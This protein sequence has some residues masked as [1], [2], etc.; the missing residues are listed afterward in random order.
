MIWNSLFKIIQ[1]CQ[2]TF[3]GKTISIPKMRRYEMLQNIYT[4]CFNCGNISIVNVK[5]DNDFPSQKQKFGLHSVQQ[6]SFYSFT[7]NVFNF[8]NWLLFGFQRLTVGER[9][10]SHTLSS[11]Y[12]E[13]TLWNAFR[14]WSGFNRCGM[15]RGRRFTYAEHRAGYY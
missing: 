13:A 12:Y 9:S 14:V 3:I 8:T 6:K 10:S 7:E 4:N 11:K 1:S 2:N 15:H 5:N